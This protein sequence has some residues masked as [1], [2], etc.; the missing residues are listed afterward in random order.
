MERKQITSVGQELEQVGNFCYLGIITT[1]DAEC[2]V[3]IKRIIAMGKDAFCK[4]KEL[5]TG[6]LN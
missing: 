5:I 6:K 4:R 2:H 3:E 1:N